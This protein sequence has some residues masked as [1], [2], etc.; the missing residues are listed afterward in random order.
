M[1]IPKKREV[2][3][4]HK[5]VSRC[6]SSHTVQGVGTGIYNKSHKVE[7]SIPLEN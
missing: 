7:S 4:V 5:T 6:I 3:E 2:V 1:T